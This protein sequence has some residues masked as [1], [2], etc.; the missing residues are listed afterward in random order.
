MFLP[1]NVGLPSLDVALPVKFRPE[2]ASNFRP[3][4]INVRCCKVGNFWYGSC[5]T[6]FVGIRAAYRV[7][8]AVGT[9]PAVQG[10]RTAPR[11]TT[12]HGGG[13]VSGPNPG[14]VT[15]GQTIQRLW[16]S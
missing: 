15:S 7:H 4:A 6:P 16:G 10:Q 9:G 3:P 5:L 2:Q 1:G 12:C 14:R 13:S 8:T 11:Q